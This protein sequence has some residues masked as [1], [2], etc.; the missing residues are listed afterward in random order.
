MNR[1]PPNQ[2]NAEIAVLGS[3]LQPEGG[4]A[5]LLEVT[6]A[7]LKPSDFY[8]EK[9]TEIYKAITSI[10]Q[11]GDPVD[12]V[13][14]TRELEDTGKLDKVGGVAYLDELIES[15]PTAANAAYHTKQVLEASQL[16]S[17]I[18]VSQ[19]V[20]FKA[21]EPQVDPA[22]LLSE[23]QSLT[24]QQRLTEIGGKI[25]SAKDDWPGVFDQL[26]RYRE[27]EYIGLRT[28]FDKFDRATLGLRG[29]SVLGGIP[30]QGKSSFALQ[31]G[32]DIAKLSRIP[33]LFYAL[34][35]AKFDIYT[36]IVSRLSKLDWRTLM[37]G[38]E[39]DG[40]RGQWLSEEDTH[41]LSEA[42]NDFME[43]GDLVKII[44]R[45]VCREISLSTLRLHIQ[46]AKQE[47][48]AD[49]VFVVIDHLQIFPC[50]RPELS[51]MKSR[52]D[53]LVAEFKAISEQYNATIL[54]ISEKNRASKGEARLDA[55]MGSAGIEYGVDLAMLFHEEGEEKGDVEAQE[56]RKI[57][58][59]VVKN[60]F[61]PR[62][63]MKMIFQ[64][65]LSAFYED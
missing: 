54:L 59:K 12:L 23:L 49:Q 31:L 14:L 35:M 58:L 11:R 29:L 10:H 9:H 57:E 40:R 44:D 33:V 13:S 51:D 24:S 1:V 65:H 8:S 20:H 64:Q 62:K 5:A 7:G 3:I 39:I 21:Y 42:S 17:I 56:E 26:C 52:I 2:P 38:S 61:G 43:Y 25:P 4:A 16:R 50:D 55:Y 63:S 60:R 27:S 18:R 22:E 45:S 30:G 48:Q 28:G 15:I 6:G 36:K 19:A 41:K 53:Y 32:A 34:E 37:I 47:H 46:Q